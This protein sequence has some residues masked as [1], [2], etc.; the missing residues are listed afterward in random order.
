VTEKPD[1]RSVLELMKEFR[2]NHLK[3]E[4]MEVTMFPQPYE[5]Q[6]LP[7]REDVL[8]G[9]EI[10]DAEKRAR[11]LQ[12]QMDMDLYADEGGDAM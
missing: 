1:L 4:G 10:M 2:V 8:E 5:A 11:Q 6:A 3:L 12:R 7:V 9:A